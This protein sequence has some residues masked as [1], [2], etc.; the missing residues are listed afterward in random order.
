MQGLENY[1]LESARTEGFRASVFTGPI[2]S[3]AGLPLG[4]EDVLIPM[5]FWK[6][7]VMPKVG[8]GLHA[9]GYLLSQGDL[10]RKFL[11]DRTGAASANESAAEGFQ[12]DE[13]RTFQFAIK[14]IEA[15]TGLRWIDLD[16]ADP[17]G[18]LHDEA[19]SLSTYVPLDSMDDLVT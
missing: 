14:H 17:L 5:E 1:I 19:V 4:K 3:D 16:G 18:A 12:L 8:G 6:I 7:V 10:I 2:L 9:T 11:E 13:F 15:A